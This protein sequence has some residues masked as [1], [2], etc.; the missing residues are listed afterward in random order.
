MIGPLA[1]FRMRALVGLALGAWLVPVLLVAGQPKAAKKAPAPA[2]RGARAVPAAPQ[3]AVAS[4]DAYSYRA[5]GRRDPFVS[6]VTRGPEGRKD[7][8]APEGVRGIFAN[9]LVLKG[10]LQSRGT[11]LAIVT[12]PDARRPYILRANDRL[13]DGVVR[14]ITGDSVLI[15]QEVNDPL[16]LTK[17]RE[18]RKTLRVVEEVK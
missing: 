16:S 4:P 6:L 3:A 12:G 5:E 1:T 11:F 2:V 15:L 14:A 10:I 9:D 13:A 7:K 8:Q 18:I 17:Q